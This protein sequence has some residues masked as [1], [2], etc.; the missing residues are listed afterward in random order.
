[1]NYTRFRSMLFAA[2]AAMGL[3]AIADGVQTLDPRFESKITVSG[4]EGAALHDFPV[5]VVISPEDI[6]G[7]DYA[8]CQSDGSDLVFE[9]AGV[10]CPYEIERWD[11]AG[12]SYVWVRL[13]TLEPGAVFYLRYGGTSVA[14]VP[15]SV[16]AGDAGSSYVG[17]WHMGESAGN[18]ADSTGHGLTGVPTGATVADD[19][20][21]TADGRIGWGRLNSH[22]DGVSGANSSYLKIDNSANLALGGHFTVSAWLKAA[23]TCDSWP[24]LM[25]TKTGNGDTKG[26]E[27]HGTNPA[28]YWGVRAAGGTK[29]DAP[30]SLKDGNWIHATFV[31][32]GETLSYY[33]NGALK[34]SATYSGQ[35]VQ[36]SPNTMSIASDSNADEWA[37]WGTLDE[38]RLRLGA[39][40]ADWIAAEHDTVAKADFLTTAPIVALTG[41]DVLQILGRP[42]KIGTVS[43]AYGIVNGLAN[44]D[45]R[46]CTAPEYVAIEGTTKRQYVT[47]WELYDADPA[48]GVVVEPAKRTSAN[49]AVEGETRLCCK[50]EHAGFAKLMWYWQLRDEPGLANEAVSVDASGAFTVTADVTGVGY[51]DDDQLTVKVAWGHSAENLAYTNDIATVAAIASVA[52]TVSS[53]TLPGAMHYARVFAVDKDGAVA[54]EAQRLL[55]FAIPAAFGYKSEPGL[56]QVRFTNAKNDWSLDPMSVEE[57]GKDES[58]TKRRR[59]LGP[60]MAYVCRTS[61]HSAVWDDDVSWQLCGSEQWAYCG[62]MYLEAGKTYK[63]R[64]Y[65]DDWQYLKLDGV[66][67][68]ENTTGAAKVLTSDGVTPSE[69]GWHAI[70][71][72]IGDGTGG[73]GGRDSTNGYKNTNNCGYS[74]DGGTTWKLLLDEENPGSMFQTANIGLGATLEVTSD[75]QVGAVDPAYGTVL[76]IPDDSSFDCFAPAVVSAEGSVSTCAG[77]QYYVEG[78]DMKSGDGNV[79]R[80]ENTNGKP[81]RLVWLWA[82]AGVPGIGESSVE[83]SKDGGFVVTAYVTGV[84]LNAGDT[85]KVMVAWGKD[86]GRLDNTNEVIVAT[87]VGP[88]SVAVPHLGQP[89]AAYYAKVFGVAG[90]GTVVESASGAV[91]FAVPYAYG[92]SEPGLWQAW[93]GDANGD[94]T[95]D[96]MS[97]PIG[98]D[99]KTCRRRELGPIMAWTWVGTPYVSD[100]WGDSL[101]WVGSSHEQFAYVGY[102]HLEQGKK[103]KF[104][105]DI[106][107][108]EYLKITDREGNAFVALN[109]A[110]GSRSVTA[111]YVSDVYEPAKTDWY[112]LEVRFSDGGGGCGGYASAGGNRKNSSNC[113]ISDDNGTTWKL[114]LD[115][116]DGSLLQTADVGLGSQLTVT[117]EPRELG[118]PDPAYGTLSGIADG[119]IFD[120]FGPAAAETEDSKATCTGWEYYV[121]DALVSH[122]DGATFRYENAGASGR[123]VWKLQSQFKVSVAAAN[124]GKV[125]VGDG[126]PVESYS[127]WVDAGTVLNVRAIPPAGESVTACWS[128]DVPAEQSLQSEIAVTVNGPCALTAGF[129][130]GT[131]CAWKGGEADD[132]ASTPENWVGGVCPVSGDVVVLT[133]AGEAFRM[134]WDLADVI[135]AGWV[136]QVNYT[137]EVVVATTFA[138]DQFPVFRIS[139]DVELSGGSWTHKPNMTNDEQF[140]LNVEIGG[141]L[142]LGAAARI[143]AT[144]KGFA[145]D[146]GFIFR[147]FYT[148]SGWLSSDWYNTYGDKFIPAHGGRGIKWTGSYLLASTPYP[149]AYGSVTCPTNCG[150]ASHF[151][152]GGGVINL[153][154]NGSAVLAGAVSADGEHK[155]VDY[156]SAGGSVWITAATMSGAGAISADGGLV[157]TAYNGGGAGGRVS[158]M[159]TQKGADFQ[160]LTGP[161]TA[162][163]SKDVQ[164]QK[165]TTPCCGTV[166][167]QTA[168]ESFGCGELTVANVDDTLFAGVATPLPSTSLCAAKELRRIRLVIG[169]NAGVCLTNDLTV[170]NF[171]LS[172]TALLDLNGKVLSVRQPWRDT[173][174]VRGQI[175]NAGEWIEDAKK[176]GYENIKWGIPGLKILFY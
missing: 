148:E 172:S 150:A 3:N 134:V 65:S 54:V 6:Q 15:T 149:E 137:N 80:Y 160:A 52:G 119:A 82:S 130:S 39:N 152:A 44:G 120:C 5:L 94:W 35:T 116:G 50:Y 22:K 76:G 110:T 66:V 123:L 139:G 12:K 38:V 78:E 167:R 56:W 147:D 53:L 1:M 157:Q 62:Y 49:T 36:D 166:Y 2:V 14:N 43:P 136:Q 168:D 42:E 162:L 165:A 71:I 156:G 30:C 98:Q 170:G 31:Y 105:T 128:G 81:G 91:G 58:R 72:R 145:I 16:W 61:Y 133:G 88:I 24:R 154:I 34:T 41:T 113:G 79:F 86:P 146:H 90:D 102:I 75:L 25:S 10:V 104:R 48:T 126:E 27:I 69:N 99:F 8:N 70:E 115:P 107:D 37:F 129:I 101:T 23:G 155:K 117:A 103:Y 87:R 132:L 84:G 114:L 97:R 158:L 135:P 4:Y 141:N 122:G 143:D 96:V 89:G 108:C 29:M 144:G 111:P 92:S 95:K 109:D 74:D 124:G 13:A 68:I 159:L 174:S 59:E 63:F 40:S 164:V 33:E 46:T 83:G 161:V 26:F 93:F 45:A 47:G 112:T 163:A 77:W 28:G 21:G 127:A 169:E 9:Q 151:A 176:P 85:M 118:A 175:L 64:M 32:D 121:G 153:K 19:S 57:G 18:V 20:K 11:T 100:L 7:F 171:S 67:M 173:S 142:T 55:S 140:R 60:L 138:A 106:D 125:K 17:V 131:V 73:A 51:G